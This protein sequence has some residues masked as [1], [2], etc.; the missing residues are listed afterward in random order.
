M[1]IIN[2]KN[3]TWI[4]NLEQRQ[5]FKSLNSIIDCEWL[6]IGAGFTGLSAAR[7][8]AQLHPR[9]K[10]ILVDAQLAGEGASSRN[11]GYLV[12]TTLNDGF[13]SNKELK[14]YKKKADIYKLGIETVN[15]FIKE[16]QVDC[17]W[18]E[19]GKYFASSKIEDAKI[20]INFSETLSKLGFEHSLLSNFEIS[21]RLGTSFYN[22]ALYTKGGILLNPGKLVRAMIDVLPNN[23]QLFE[24]SS[25]LKWKII[26]NKVI[27]N[28]KNGIINSKKV[29][30][31]T[32]GFLKSS[33]IKKRYNFPLTLTAS[34][35]RPLTDEEFKSIGQPREWGVLPIRPMGA[36]VRMTKDR[37]ILIRNTAEIYNPNHMTQVDLDKRSI[38]QKI[39]IKKRF[40]QLPSNIIQSSWSGIVSRTRNGSQIFEKINKNIFVAGCYN[41]SGI[42]VGS[43]FG[44]QIAIKASNE[45]SK[46]IE[47]IEA[48][49]KPTWL[50][51]QPFLNLGVKARLMYERHRAKSEI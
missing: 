7:K 49:N 23:V 30:F 16:Y 43:L 41:G 35:T 11:S 26:N 28:F 3:C 40:P 1:K 13:T 27:C 8:L 45:F 6:I 38:K 24:N 31:A 47:I 14:N 37:R 48:R 51:P 18:N 32:N 33:G 4:N 15:K 10:I 9:Q 36:T 34:M 46:E 21:K 25:L 39:G 29:I 42:G 12:D 2:D 19:C 50:P 17:D 44:E 5:N 20:L 22:I